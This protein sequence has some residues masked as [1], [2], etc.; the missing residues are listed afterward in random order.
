M[1]R[2]RPGIIAYQ[3]G[4]PVGWCI[5]SP[6]SQIPLLAKSTPT[7]PVNEVDSWSIICT[8]ARPGYRRQ[9]VNRRR[10]Q[11]A[12]DLCPKPWH[13]GGGDQPC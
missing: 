3:D 8:V 11:G 1:S 7:R 4:V 5:I 10:L 12:V 13:A 6:H 9:G 2:L